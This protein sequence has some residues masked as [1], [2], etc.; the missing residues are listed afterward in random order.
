[1]LRY[2]SQDLAIFS[3]CSGVGSVIFDEAVFFRGPLRPL[4]LPDFSVRFSQLLIEIVFVNRHPHAKVTGRQNVRTPQSEH[5]EHMRG[6][7]AY[8]LTCVRCSITSSFRHFWQSRKI[9]L[10]A[11]STFG[12][13]KQIRR[14][15]AWKVLRAHL[16]RREFQNAS[17]VRGSPANAANRLKIV[18]AALPFNC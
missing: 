8:A 13:V 7:H 6:P 5:Q 9:Q 10:A 15:S 1:M 2:G 14:L 3:I 12:H 17:G 16:L 18:T 11:V 4:S